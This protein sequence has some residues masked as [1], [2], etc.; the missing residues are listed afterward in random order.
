MGQLL[1]ADE[2]F[3][4]NSVMGVMPVCRVERRAIADDKPGPL[5]LRLME[6]YEQRV[7]AETNAG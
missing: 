4:T 3:V 7:E 6:A 1:E 2:V 5:T